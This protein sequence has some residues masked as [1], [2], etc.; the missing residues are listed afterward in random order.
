MPTKRD[1]PTGQNTNLFPPTE[2]EQLKRKKTE[3]KQLNIEQH[4]QSQQIKTTNKQTI[5]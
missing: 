4:K 1:F 2:P 5:I 3:K